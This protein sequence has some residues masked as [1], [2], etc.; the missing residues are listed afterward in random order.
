MYDVIVTEAADQDLDSIIAYICNSLHNPEAATGLLN[1]I[2]ECYSHLEQSPEMYAL[3]KDKRLRDAG[4]RKAVIHSYLM[5]YRFDESS[6]K[7]FV[8]RYFY[9]AQN[10]ENII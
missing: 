5:I 8:L 7:V 2:E 3:C 6:G 9:G 4:Y 1:V 10:Y